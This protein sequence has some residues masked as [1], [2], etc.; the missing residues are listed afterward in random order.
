[1]V[2]EP[3]PFLPKAHERHSLCSEFDFVNELYVAFEML[4]VFENEPSGLA[5]WVTTLYPSFR[6]S[7][8]KV[9][10]FNVIHHLCRA[11]KSAHP[12]FIAL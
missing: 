9:N 4:Q 7:S 5:R 12:L 11:G 10:A 2:F 8:F 6:V 1:V 3:R